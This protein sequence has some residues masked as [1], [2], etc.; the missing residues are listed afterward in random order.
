MHQLIGHC[1]SSKST[2][3]N[4]LGTIFPSK[5][6]LLFEIFHCDLEREPGHNTQ[7][8]AEPNRTNQKGDGIIVIC[9]KKMVKYRK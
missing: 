8:H 9:C 1:H 2:T 5:F 6:H 4:M 7:P 3:A